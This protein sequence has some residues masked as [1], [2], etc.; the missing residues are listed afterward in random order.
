MNK[1]KEAAIGL[2]CCGCVFLILSVPILASAG[3]NPWG[4]WGGFFL[5]LLVAGIFFSVA[6]A[7]YCI[8]LTS[9]ITHRRI[10]DAFKKITIVKKKCQCC[11]ELYEM[12]TQESMPPESLLTGI[13]E[14]E[15]LNLFNLHECDAGLCWRLRDLHELLDGDDDK[16]MCQECREEEM[17]QEIAE[18][19]QQIEQQIKQEHTNRVKLV[20][21]WRNKRSTASW[22]NHTWTKCG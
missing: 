16:S 8:F 19:H 13:Y 10:L 20:N 5:F 6:Y 15:A 14:Y 17:Q 1:D 12:V 9:Y 22:L 21:D 4:A 11:G 7:S 2:F 3:R 18:R